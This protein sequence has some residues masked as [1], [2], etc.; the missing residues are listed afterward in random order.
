MLSIPPRQGA[1]GS[2]VIEQ[3]RERYGDV[4][5]VHRL[6]KET[7]GLMISARTAGAH[8]HLNLQFQE[9]EVEK[10]Y[11]ALV[12]GQSWETEFEVDAAIIP[13]SGQSRKALI[14]ATAGKPSL[15]NFAVEESFRNY[16][17]IRAFP[18][19]GRS[20]Q[21]RVH[22]ELMQLSIVGDPLYGGPEAFFLS[23]IKKNYKAP[24]EGE[25]PI[26]SRMALHSASL[27][28]KHP[29]SDEF[30]HIEA[31]LH[32]DFSACLNQLRKHATSSY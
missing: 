26:M 32:K 24:P 7:S 22:L 6:D 21:I 16:Q 30:L 2:S 1:D 14:H 15:T 29:E 19:T 10:T 4:Y 5:V 25:L 17:L 27:D 18:Y 9:R 31:P 11:L 20:H 13:G 8:K 28:F 12:K 23:E 3:L